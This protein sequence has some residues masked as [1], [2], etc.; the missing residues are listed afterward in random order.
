M[1]IPRGVVRHGE[2]VLRLIR[3]RGSHPEPVVVDAARDVYQ[4]WTP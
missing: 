3:E 1:M 2:G 4:E